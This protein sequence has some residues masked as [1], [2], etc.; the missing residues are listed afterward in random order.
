M[1]LKKPIQSN[2]IKKLKSYLTSK[3]FD[4]NKYKQQ[5]KKEGKSNYVK[6]NDWIDVIKLL[7]VVFPEI[8]KYNYLS[9]VYGYSIYKGILD[10]NIERIF[11]LFYDTHT[12]LNE[13]DDDI[14]NT[15]RINKYLF[16]SFKY[17]DEKKFTIDFFIKSARIKKN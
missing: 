3:N 6:K 7:D 16:D 5:R 2:T 8:K 9:G 1:E 14:N 17:A 4:F 15:M 12:L 10:D 13:C 11:Y